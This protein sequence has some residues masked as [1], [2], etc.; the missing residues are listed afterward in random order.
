M[1]TNTNCICKK[2]EYLPDEIIRLIKEYI[3]IKILVFTNKENYNLYH[4]YMK[5]YIINY[6]NYIR[7]TI[8]RDN[9]FVFNKILEENYKKWLDIKKYIYKNTIYKNY[10]YF[11]IDYCIENLSTQC[12]NIITIFLRQNGLCQNQHKKNISKHIR[13]KT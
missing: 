4:S 1:N 9:S 3:P 2:I 7:D 12:R 10:I 11:V 8:R 6:E 13:W 5:K